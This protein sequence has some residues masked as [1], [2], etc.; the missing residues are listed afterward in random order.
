M[1][2][3][4]PR[5]ARNQR[6]NSRKKTPLYK[7]SDAVREFNG[8]RSASETESYR[9]EFRRDF[10]RLL[11]C[12]SFRRLQGKT[13][14]FPSEEHDFY[15]TRLTHSLEVAQIAKSI[16]IKINATGEYFSNERH[17]Q[18]D[19]DLVEFA[20]LAHDLG[21]PPF[22]HNGEYVLDELMLNYGG[23]EGNAQTLRILARLEKKVTTTKPYYTSFEDSNDLRRGLNLTSRTLASI[24]KYDHQIPKTVAE[25][26]ARNSEKKPDKG[27]Y[28][29]DLDI[30]RFVKQTIGGQPAAFK[31][32]ECSIMDLADDIAYSTYD[33]EDAF[34]AGFLNPISILSVSDELKSS[35]ATSIQEKINKEYD[36]LDD[37][38]RSFN[39]DDLNTALTSVFSSVLKITNTVFERSWSGS[40]L[41]AYVGSE[42]HKAS[43]VLSKSSYQRTQFTSDLIGQ[44]VRSVN[45]YKKGPD[46]VFWQ[47]R[48]S[49][50]EFAAI[51]TLKAVAMNLLIRSDKFLA[52]KHRAK[53]IITSIFNALKESGSELLPQDWKEVYD[54]YRDDEGQRL[55]TICDF[56]SG[57]TNRYCVEFYERLFSVRPPS[58]HK[59]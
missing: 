23:F 56:V 14:L 48:P 49:V 20:G 3:S 53:H 7:V 9:T 29:C 33:I 37:D 44:F 27:Y 36:D 57:M 5:P 16:A 22:G 10:Q 28:S 31:T 30:V 58:I 25:R 24:L 15:R 34:A 51:E 50:G 17:S 52:E 18:I 6:G 43:T 47:V 59:P 40:E 38:E 45:V 35:I 26:R 39:I 32:I 12:P 55:R 46:P 54:H 1:A 11:H 4:G 42:V 19:L 2:T 41:G 8:E 13:Q 21:H